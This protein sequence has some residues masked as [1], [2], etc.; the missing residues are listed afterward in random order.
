MNLARSEFR[1]MSKVAER[2]IISDSNRQRNMRI[3][4]L[5]EHHISNKATNNKVID[6]RKPL[7]SKQSLSVGTAIRSD[8]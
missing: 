6:C 3:R 7:K 2:V 4:K 1:E 5:N 8:D